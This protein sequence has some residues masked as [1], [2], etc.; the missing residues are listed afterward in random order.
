MKRAILLFFCVIMCF[1]GDLNLMFWNVENLFDIDDDPKKR[2]NDFLPGGAKRYTYRSYCLKLQ[3]LAD[4]INH[5]KPDLLGMVEVENRKVLKALCEKLVFRDQWRIIIN[6]GPD[7]RGIDPALIYRSDKF[8]YCS[9]GYYPVFIKERGYHSRS[10][11]RVDLAVVHGYDTLS[12]FINHWPSRR[13][14]KTASDP[15]RN[16]AAGILTAAIDETLTE[17]PDRRVIITGDFN[18]DRYDDCLNILEDF[19]CKYL[20]KECPPKVFGTYYHEGEWIHFDHFL[21][22]NFSQ[23]AL[24]VK[25]TL[26]QAPF[27][28][29]EKDTNGPLRFYKG[30]ENAGGYSDHYPI[31]LKL[32]NDRKNV[33]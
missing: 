29:R 23:A 30:L 19:G 17:H 24:S 18:D 32:S 28:I 10:I 21:V 3:H 7:I 26:I 14:G 25:K 33:E 9:H 6:D 12:I 2:D 5:A 16:F 22:Y 15:F 13:G 8:V 1:A 27:W 31:L 4:V 20:V 11:M